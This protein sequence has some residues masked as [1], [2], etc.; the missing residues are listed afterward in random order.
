MGIK[1][2]LSADEMLPGRIA[3][4]IHTTKKWVVH[5]QNC[6]IGVLDLCI[7]QVSYYSVISNGTQL[8]SVP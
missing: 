6:I 7:L 4:G 1:Q 8:L 2:F 5:K 3:S